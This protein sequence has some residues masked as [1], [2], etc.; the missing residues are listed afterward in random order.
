MDTS[1]NS[2]QRITHPEKIWKFPVGQDELRTRFLRGKLQTWLAG[3]IAERKFFSPVPAAFA[4]I[5]DGA[6]FVTVGDNLSDPDQQQA[7]HPRE[8]LWLL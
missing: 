2:G 1:P 5:K 8:S 6:L 3:R 7:T 4:S